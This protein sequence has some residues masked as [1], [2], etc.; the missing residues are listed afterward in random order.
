MCTSRTKSAD[1]DAV[2]L[3]GGDGDGTRRTQD[4]RAGVRPSCSLRWC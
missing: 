4:G 2:A 1:N 3:P